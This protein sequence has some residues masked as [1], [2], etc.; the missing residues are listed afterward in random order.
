MSEAPE[1]NWRSEFSSA[2]FELL[3]DVFPKAI[4][5]CQDRSAR[6]HAEYAD[7]DGHQYLYGNG[8]ARGVQKDLQP[9]IKDLASYRE[10]TVP[11]THRSLMFIGRA[12]LFSL[13]VG[14]KMPRNHLKVR[15]KYLPEARRE[16]LSSTSNE[17][18]REPGLFDVPPPVVNQDEVAQLSDVLR[19]LGKFDGPVTLFPIYYSST[20]FSLGKM[21]WGPAQLSGRYLQF[22]DPDLL[23]FR[24]LPSSSQKKESK[25]RATGGFAD[26]ERP[27]TQAKLRRPRDDERANQ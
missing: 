11:G 20:P 4:Q 6:A 5:T 12:L 26:G 18:Y 19:L 3:S 14:N 22:T 23:T 24:K 8:M 2:D 16:L 21:Y 17:K 7:P 10:E 27:P 9:L 15:L 13:R 25:P 1:L